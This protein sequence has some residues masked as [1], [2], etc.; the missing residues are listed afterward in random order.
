[1]ATESEIA[2]I[3]HDSTVEAKKVTLVS[4]TG[5]A[6]SPAAIGHGSK[7]VTT[8]GTDVTLAAST[9]CKSVTIQA[10]ESNTGF[11]AVGATGVDAGAAGTGIRLAAGDTFSLEI[12]NL[13]SV[14]IDST[15]NGEGVRFTYT[16]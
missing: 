4:G 7:T 11:I 9:A 13:A 6:S 2:N 15:V 12:A 1:M 8:A 14:Y 3:E 10:Y 16:V 5:G